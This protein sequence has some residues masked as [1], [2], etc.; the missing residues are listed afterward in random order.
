[1]QAGSM[2]MPSSSTTRLG[3]LARPTSCDVGYNNGVVFDDRG[4][5]AACLK[6]PAT[7]S[8]EAAAT[9]PDQ[10]GEIFGDGSGFI[11]HHS[12]FRI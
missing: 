7:P 9:P 1:M 10:G 11:I 6:R 4:G 12:S 8:A 2:A 5:R 3:S